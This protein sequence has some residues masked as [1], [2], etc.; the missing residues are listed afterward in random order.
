VFALGNA[1]VHDGFDGSFLDA[2]G[3]FDLLAVFAD[4]ICDDRLGSVFV[5]G[6]GLLRE[7]EGIL[8]LFFGPVGATLIFI[9]A[10]STSGL[11]GSLPCYS[12]HGCRFV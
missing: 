10:I 8:V 12:R 2:P 5:L 4:R 9:S 11:E 3:G 7:L 1:G 6:D